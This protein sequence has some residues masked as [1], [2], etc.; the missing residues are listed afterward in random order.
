VYRIQFI[1]MIIFLSSCSEK[2]KSTSISK[3]KIDT[4]YIT[5]E[6]RGNF[7]LSYKFDSLDKNK[8]IP[9][10]KWILVQVKGVGEMVKILKHSDLYLESTDSNFII[11]RI[12]NFEY[13][14]Y[15]RN[16][17]V[18][19]IPNGGPIAE[20]ECIEIYPYITPHKGY[21]LDAYWQDKPI[22]FSEKTMVLRNLFGL[23][24]K[25]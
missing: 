14:F 4:L 16:S 24:M 8:F 7:D 19:Y 6:M 1:L 9:R 3:N 17:Y 5:E 13:K 11:Q 2:N 15:V 20:Q 12:S 21:I 25:N 18:G 22:A 23:E 10:N